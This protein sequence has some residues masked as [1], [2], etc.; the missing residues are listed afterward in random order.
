MKQ[1]WKDVPMEIEVATVVATPSP[2][3]SSHNNWERKLK[4]FLEL[5]GDSFTKQTMDA[6]F[7]MLLHDKWKIENDVQVLSMICV[8]R[9]TWTASEGLP[10]H[11]EKLQSSLE[12][13]TLTRTS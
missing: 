10:N 11:S 1:T 12:A 6:S 7:H 4:L 9:T 2:A 13:S 3:L 8:V 5:L